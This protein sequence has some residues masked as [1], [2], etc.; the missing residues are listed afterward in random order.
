MYIIPPALYPTTL[1]ASIHILNPI[2]TIF[3]IQITALRVSILSMKLAAVMIHRAFSNH[4]ADGSFHPTP[5]SG[6]SR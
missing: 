2:I 1:F 4:C 6:V 3:N 5:F